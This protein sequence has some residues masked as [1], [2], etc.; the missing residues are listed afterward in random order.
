MVLQS[1]GS[2]TAVGQNGHCQ[3]D[4]P[5]CE[6]GLRYTQIAAGRDHTVLL[7]SDGTV[8]G[9][10]ANCNGECT[11]P[12]LSKG[13]RYTRVAAGDHH[14]L[15]HVSDGRILAVG[16]NDDQQCDLPAIWAAG[17]ATDEG[18]K[19]REDAA[20][21]QAVSSEG[22]QG[23]APPKAWKR[24]PKAACKMPEGGD[25]P[26]RARIP[27]KLARRKK[28]GEGSESSSAAAQSRSPLMSPILM[29]DAA[30]S[31]IRENPDSLSLD[32][33]DKQQVVKRSLRPP[34]KPK[35]PDRPRSEELGVDIRT[36]KLSSGKD[37]RPKLLRTR[38]NEQPRSSSL[39][40]PTQSGGATP[41]LTSWRADAEEHCSSSRTKSGSRPR[42]KKLALQR[43]RSPKEHKEEPEVQSNLLL[44]NGTSSTTATGISGL[45]D[46]SHQPSGASTSSHLSFHAK[47]AWPAR[48]E[49]E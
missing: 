49:T 21:I 12:Q 34:A 4:I 42:P 45:Q 20:A 1:N 46:V 33:D 8:E 25:V 37:A 19:L 36:A 13:L 27:K 40:L 43:Q 15:L 7:R 11:F 35:A 26:A 2:A 30:D 5:D 3:C 9:V 17:E 31:F 48:M 41:G 29:P 10:G 22:S 39:H 32:G 44:R 24:S 28:V 14:T 6:P 47:G 23:K 18:A 16:K 38:S